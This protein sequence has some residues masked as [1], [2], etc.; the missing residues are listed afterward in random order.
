[1][2]AVLSFVPFFEKNLLKIFKYIWE[3]KWKQVKFLNGSLL[4]ETDTPMQE[5]IVINGHVYCFSGYVFID[6][7]SFIPLGFLFFYFLSTA[8][9]HGLKAGT[10]DTMESKTT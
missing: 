5:D 1:M 2:R 3:T 6:V 7:E 10:G 8:M 4:R 9:S